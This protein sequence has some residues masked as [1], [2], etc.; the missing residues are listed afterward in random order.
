MITQ[1]HE[2]TEYSIETGEV[3]AKNIIGYNHKYNYQFAETY[4][5]K[6]G[7]KK[8]GESGYKAAMNEM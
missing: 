7:I 1:G 2:I 5:L 8:F 4:G 3:I 6:K